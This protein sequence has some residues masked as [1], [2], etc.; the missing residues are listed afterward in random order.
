MWP[1]QW[2]WPG[3]REGLLGICLRAKHSLAW[4]GVSILDLGGCKHIA[5]LKSFVERGS[6][7]FCSLSTFLVLPGCNLLGTVVQ[8]FHLSPNFPPWNCIRNSWTPPPGWRWWSPRSRPP[9]HWWCSSRP[10]PAP[11]RALARGSR[12]EDFVKKKYFGDTW[13]EPCTPTRSPS[14]L[15]RQCW[16]CHPWRWWDW[17][18]FD[19]NLNFEWIYWGEGTWATLLICET[20]G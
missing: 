13:Q 10:A 6:G 19:K 15:Q 12:W 16:S 1:Q 4:V 3:C 9:P 2:M 8:S 14:W 20:L 5:T 7:W 17:I 11:Q 18:Q